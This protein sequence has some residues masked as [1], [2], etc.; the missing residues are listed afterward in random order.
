MARVLV[1][2]PA[3]ERTA[4]LEPMLRARNH[5]ALVSNDFAHATLLLRMFKP[6]VVIAP[7]ILRAAERE[8]LATVAA[9]PIVILADLQVGGQVTLTSEGIA[10]V[11][12]STPSQAELDAVL[13]APLSRER[14]VAR[15]LAQLARSSATGSLKLSA[16]DSD[17]V[18]SMVV[19][20]NGR[21]TATRRGPDLRTLQALET[22]VRATF[23]AG[24]DDDAD[25][26]V[27]FEELAF[28]L[29][30]DDDPV[31]PIAPEVRAEALAR[32]AP[33]RLVLADGDRDLLRFRAGFLRRH[34]YVVDTAV[35]GDEALALMRRTV[36][37]VVIADATMAGRSGWDLLGLV[38]SSAALRE[39]PVVLTAY[40]GTWLSRLKRAGCGADAV[41]ENG[42]RAD[43]LVTAVE[44][45]A[46]PG[47]QL[48]VA[49]EAARM[50]GPLD[51]HLRGAGPYTLLRL[52]A[53]RRFSGRVALTVGDARFLVVV[54]DGGLVFARVSSNGTTQ[55]HGAA[56]AALLDVGAVGF[57]LTHDA[58]VGPPAAS[59]EEMLALAV[60]DQDRRAEDAQRGLL[61]DGKQL[62]VRGDLLAAYRAT[63]D[64]S[65]RPVVDQLASG[66]DARDLLARGIDP[67]LVDEVFRDLFRKGAVRTW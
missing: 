55:M 67:M 21:V 9:T 59:L 51:A 31:T 12:P 61:A 14:P 22:P 6:D 44:R 57:S 25:I 4:A 48:A 27:D 8:M 19:V 23:V 18:L 60:V 47:R 35:D 39:T 66:R 2:G 46:G 53:Q 33:V 40:D 13:G 11:L 37:D 58:A 26:A 54:H 36:P 1:V 32:L 5:S 56:V 63:C 28:E 29:E 20:E 38:R 45:L 24:L 52:L 64:A 42:L 15:V 49:L 10:R 43:R 41:V 7:R 62:A 65:W 34:G 50:V 3:D 16:V 30:D 17:D